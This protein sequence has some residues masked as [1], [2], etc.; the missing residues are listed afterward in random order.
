MDLAEAAELLPVDEG[1][2]AAERGV[3]DGGDDLRG[4]DNDPRLCMSSSCIA[5]AGGDA[6]GDGEQGLARGARALSRRVSVM[7]WWVASV[8]RLL[9]PPGPLAASAASSAARA[10]SCVLDEATI[11]ALFSCCGAADGNSKTGAASSSPV[12]TAKGCGSGG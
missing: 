9:L 6:A 1:A 2:K 5:A 12:R 4:G 10:A 11:A 3:D 7:V 8:V